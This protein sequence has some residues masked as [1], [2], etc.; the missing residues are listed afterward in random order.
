MIERY[1]LAIIREVKRRGTL[2]E[3]AEHLCLTQ[4]A[5]SH[6][7]KKL[8]Q[9]IGVSIWTK[10]GRT[11]SWTQAGQSLLALANRLLPQFEQAEELMQQ[12]AQGHRGNLRIGMECHPCYQWLLKT[13]SPFLKKWPDVDVDVK[14]RFQFGGI[15]ALFAC[16][17]D[18][19]ITPDPMLKKG[20]EFTPVF[21]YELMLVVNK[22][23]VLA[24]KDYVVPEQLADD[25]LITYPVAKE[26]LDIYSRF[27]LPQN[28]SPK[29]HK[30]IE[31]TDVMLEMVAANRGITALPGWLVKK[32]QPLLPLQAVRL[33]KEGIHK[34]IYIG[35][36]DSD[37]Q[38]DYI[39]DFVKQAKSVTDS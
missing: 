27:L 2:T 12:Y 11:L 34:H 8:E 29:R 31:T 24:S 16:D 32:Y 17:I 10:E 30:T 14:Q 33:G 20:L 6:A 19:L 1:H 4:S 13:V 7:I 26:R 25:I 38:I 35:K 18:L 5:L 15:G 23:H 21:A 37:E 36:R 28:C 39:N 22:T 3:A 9:N